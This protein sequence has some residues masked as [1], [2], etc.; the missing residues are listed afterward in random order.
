[1]KKLAKRLNRK[2]FTLVETMLAVFI[3]VVISTMLINGFIINIGK[4][5]IS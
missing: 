5:N 3:L 1:M 2:G 4:E